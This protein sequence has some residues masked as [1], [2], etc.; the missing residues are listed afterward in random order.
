[1]KAY[2]FH[3][4]CYTYHWSASI[5]ENLLYIPEKSIIVYI[6]Q[7]GSKTSMGINSKKDT[8]KIA[9]EYVHECLT[10][11]I[12]K[13]V[14]EEKNVTTI[15]S[16]NGPAGI[17]STSMPGLYSTLISNQQ[18][19]QKT[20]KSGTYPVTLSRFCEVETNITDEDIERIK[21]MSVHIGHIEK[22]LSEFTECQRKMVEKWVK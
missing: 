9:Q 6:S 19:Y 15:S 17:Y 11:I 2:K 18:E 14:K 4:S 20:Y 7:S 12:P 8:L 21:D 3:L 16:I 1:M 10:G 22:A 13:N 5:G